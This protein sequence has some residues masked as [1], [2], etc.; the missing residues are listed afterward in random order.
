[1]SDIFN[2][3]WT[4]ITMFLSLLNI[5]VGLLLDLKVFGIPFLVYLVFFDLMVNLMVFF[6]NGSFIFDD[7]DDD[8]GDDDDD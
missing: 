3:A 6:G 4:G 5:A 7:G 1:M 8:E 2:F